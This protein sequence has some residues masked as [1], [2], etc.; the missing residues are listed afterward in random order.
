MSKN[1]LGC[2]TQA[3]TR[4]LCCR[5]ANYWW[6]VSAG[7]M[8]ESMPAMQPPPA[9]TKPPAAI[10]LPGRRLKQVSTLHIISLVGGKT[11]LSLMDI[12]GIFSDVSRLDQQSIQCSGR[13]VCVP[14]NLVTRAAARCDHR[15]LV[16]GCLLFLRNSALYN[17]SENKHQE[18]PRKF[19]LKIP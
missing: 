11:I 17:I 12:R 18:I 2:R 1:D 15:R 10:S 7:G 16:A 4:W 19:L 8:W 6:C 9:A 5:E 3:G 14:G 13:Q